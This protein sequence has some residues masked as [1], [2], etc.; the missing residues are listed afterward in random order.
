M[1][2]EVCHNTLYMWSVQYICDSTFSVLPVSPTMEPSLASHTVAVSTSP[3]PLVS[4]MSIILRRPSGVTC[5]ANNS[6]CMARNWERNL[7]PH[8]TWTHSGSNIVVLLCCPSTAKRGNIFVE[9]KCCACGKRG[10][11][12]GSM[13]PSAML[14][15]QCVLVLRPLS[16]IFHLSCQL[17]VFRKRA[18]VLLSKIAF[19]I[20]VSCCKTFLV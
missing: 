16:H 5:K 11:L 17:S 13:I 4:T 18:S 1:L 2:F 12:L 10:H 14:P 6:H 9:H 3:L 19:P 20:I 15:P 7:G 8:K